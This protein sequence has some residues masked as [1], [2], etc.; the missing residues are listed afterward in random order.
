MT[1]SKKRTHCYYRT[2][3]R[4]FFAKAYEMGLQGNIDKK[5]IE[6]EFT[7]IFDSYNKNLTFLRDFK[8]K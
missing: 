6:E 8:E 5:G 7:F 3:L 2:C 4:Q 1:L